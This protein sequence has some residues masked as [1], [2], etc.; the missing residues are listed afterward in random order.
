LCMSPSTKSASKH[1]SEKSETKSATRSNRVLEMPRDGN[2]KPK[3]PLP[4]QHQQKPGIESKVR[5]R[6]K[7]LAPQYKGSEK[8]LDKAAIV[9]GGDSGIGRATAVLFAREGAD[10][11]IIYLKAEQSDAEETQQA[12]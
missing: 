10:V 12:I 5:P 6:P 2:R 3:N 7:Y 11:A 4:A 1:N 8:L 9:T